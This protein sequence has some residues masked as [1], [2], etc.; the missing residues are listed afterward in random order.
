MGMT[1]WA[2]IGDFAASAADEVAGWFGGSSGNGTGVAAAGYQQPA[3]LQQHLK[4][5]GA[6]DAWVADALKPAMAQIM[7]M[8]S[9]KAG[10]APRSTG[11]TASAKPVGGNAA[12]AMEVPKMIGKAAGNNPLSDIQGWGNLF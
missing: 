5:I 2:A 8:T 9:R 4:D 1:T 11:A 10:G 3:E 7:Q 6:T 12:S